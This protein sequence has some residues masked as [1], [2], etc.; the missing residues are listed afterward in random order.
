MPRIYCAVCVY[1]M[2]VYWPRSG[3]EG[4]LPCCQTV[5]LHLEMLL[6]LAGPPP[7]VENTICTKANREADG[8]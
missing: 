3:R 6:T 1:V 8:R 7:A 5:G 2:Y 4:D